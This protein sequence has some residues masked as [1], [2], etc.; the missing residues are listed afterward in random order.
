[1]TER[2]PRDAQSDA[3]SDPLAQPAPAVSD[4]PAPV[5]SLTATARGV[6][7]ALLVSL[8]ANLMVAG[9]VVGALMRPHHRVGHAMQQGATFAPYIE[10][11]PRADRRAMRVEMFRL[12]PELVD[13][14]T[15]R[16]AEMAE[17][18]RIVATEPFDPA[19]AARLIDARLAEG[20]GR[21][22]AARDLLLDRLAGM[23]PQTRRAYG[24]R[25]AEMAGLPDR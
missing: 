10:A 12:R 22:S 21:L 13:L 17:F 25:L 24:A 9:L 6:K 5:R 20:A 8:A 14:R 11:L 16:R 23:P 15:A 19:A 7:I 2:D 1:M 18:A 3:Q 4:A